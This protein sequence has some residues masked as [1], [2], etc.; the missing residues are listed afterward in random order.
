MQTTPTT[1]PMKVTPLG[2]SLSPLCEFSQALR[3]S[4]FQFE[5]GDG[6]C[7]AS[8]GRPEKVGFCITGV[9]SKAD[10]Q[11]LKLCWDSHDG[12]VVELAHWQAMCQAIGK[13]LE[14]IIIAV[15]PS[16]TIAP[17]GTV[18]RFTPPDEHVRQSWEM[19]SQAINEALVAPQPQPDTEER[20]MERARR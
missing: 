17:D 8:V 7:G 13:K 16:P 19:L 12:L 18:Y 14:R 20:E 2:N 9:I 5:A 1:G 4:M 10:A 11:R 6:Y 15:C 3:D